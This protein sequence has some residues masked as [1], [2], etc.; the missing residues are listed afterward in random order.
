MAWGE[1]NGM[2]IVDQSL[3][4]EGH[5]DFSC[6]LFEPGCEPVKSS[7]ALQSEHVVRVFVNGELVMNL[8]C[9]PDHI[10]ELVVGRLYTE[11]MI[12]GVDEV[13]EV[14][15]C[16]HSSR[17]LVYLRNCQAVAVPKGRMVQD[18][19]TC[20]TDNR[21][22]SSL[23]L[24]DEELPQVKAIPW[25]AEDVFALARA[26][27]G[28]TPMHRRTFGAHSC[29]LA[30]GCKVLYCCEDLGRHNAF[31]KVVGCALRDGV[32][33]RECTVFTSGR[34]PTDMAVKAVRARIPIMVSKAVPTD[35]AVQM[36]AEH[37]LTLICSAHSDSFMV[38]NDP[39]TK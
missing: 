13:D 23:F 17:V 18:V 36:A 6:E 10:V 32:D 22:L 2:R 31:D 29:Y 38:M 14:W 20:C 11:G 8:T 37:G 1:R 9:S 27:E 19:G 28:D 39:L 7:Y 26:F 4:L 35:L 34:V 33:L 5:A 21:T 24:R 30:R 16:E 25:S 15:L 3:G 12:A